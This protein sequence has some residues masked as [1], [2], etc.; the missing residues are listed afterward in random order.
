M[1]SCGLFILSLF[2]FPNSL[3]EEYRWLVLLLI[4]LFFL[5]INPKVINAVLKIAGKLFKRELAIPMTYTQ[6]LK[7]VLLFIGNWLIAGVGF[8]ILVRAVYP[9]A[10]LSQ[11]LYCGGVWGIAAIAGI[12]A[13][14][15]PSGLGV[16]EGMVV[17]GLSLIMPTE[18][19]V[20]VSVASRLWV[21]IP[22]LVL[23]AGA[24][25]VNRLHR[26]KD[27]A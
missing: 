7:A 11:L 19:A 18:Y 5:C 22:E 8:Y 21:T 13:V 23:A 20:L 14:F 6:T 10:E 9:Q 2:F 16:R 27:G 25:I 15:A 24:F 3:L 12:L 1:Q 4:A 17:A 26:N